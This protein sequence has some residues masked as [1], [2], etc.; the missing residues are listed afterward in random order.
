M[1]YSREKKAFS[2]IRSAKSFTH[3]FR[4]IRVFIATTN[5][6]WVQFFA[7]G[8][9]MLLGFYFCIS[10]MEWIALIF[11]VTLVI[12]TEAINTAL[13]FDIDLTS[14][15]FHPFARDTKDIAAGAVLLSAIAAVVVG[16]IIFVP[17]IA[18]VL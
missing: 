13:E 11:A 3:A 17:K 2:L 9:A 7:A 4:G 15:E 1:E 16:L 14:P 8:V 18:G 10:A 5:N 6:V 12:V